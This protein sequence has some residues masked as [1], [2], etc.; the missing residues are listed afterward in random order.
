MESFKHGILPKRTKQGI[1]QDFNVEISQKGKRK[2]NVNFLEISG[3]DIKSIVPSLNP[4]K[5]PS[6]HSFLDRYLMPDNG[7]NKR[8]IFVSDGEKHRIGT[9]TDINNFSEDT[10]FDAFLRYLLGDTQKALKEINILFVISKWDVVRDDYKNDVQKYMKRNFPQ[11]LSILDGNRVNVM[12]LPFTIG[13]IE[14]KLIDRENDIYENRIT[15]LENTH[16]DRLI[17]WIYHTFTGETLKGFPPI[18]PSF[19][20]RIAKILRIR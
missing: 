12:Y 1:I 5:K 19:L 14:E 8:F 4:D 7:I 2:L 15:S 11:T 9:N 10:L 13:K 17:Q 3:E 20:Y 16:I 6:I 18:K